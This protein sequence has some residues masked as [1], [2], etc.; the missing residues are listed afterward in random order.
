MSVHWTGLIE[1]KQQLGAIPANLLASS[2]GAVELATQQVAA[3]LRAIYPVG[4]A[5]R[6]RNGRPI[7]PGGLRRG[8][9]TS[10][11]TTATGTVGTVTSTAPHAHLWEFGTVSR[12]WTRRKSHK[13]VGQ[14]P[15]Q[16][17]KGV[18]GQAIRERRILEA[19]LIAQ[20][21][22]AGFTVNGQ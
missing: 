5:G 20:V 15:A 8:V 14:M 2:R 16:Y 4:T 9:R 21:R 17:G 13:Y 7:S 6:L 22:N 1:L 3:G 12:N 18:V 19:Q 11:K 10:I